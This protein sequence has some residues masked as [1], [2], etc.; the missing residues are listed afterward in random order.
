MDD[1]LLMSLLGTEVALQF[2]KTTTK[3]FPAL[4]SLGSFPLSVR[5]DSKVLLDNIADA[6]NTIDLASPRLEK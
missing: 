1:I 3:T 5:V 6:L 4:L 2:D